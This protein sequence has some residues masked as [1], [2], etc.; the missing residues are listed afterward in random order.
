MQFKKNKMK[1]IEYKKLD[2]CYICLDN[3]ELKMFDCIG[4]HY[5]TMCTIKLDNCP[6][7]R[8][9]K[10]VSNYTYLLN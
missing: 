2:E 9:P 6:I 3:T 8:E 10:V 5:C 4:H 7:C 1:L